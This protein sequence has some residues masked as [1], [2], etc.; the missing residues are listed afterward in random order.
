MR[1]KFYSVG[2][3]MK[4]SDNI[5]TPA[6]LAF[7]V[8]AYLLWGILPL[9]IKLLD[10][11]PTAEIVA[12]RVVWSVPIAGLA[13]VALGRTADIR[14]ALVSPST[15]AMGALMAALV[16]INWGIYIWAIGSCNTLDAALGY[17]IN[18]LFS[19]ALGALFLGERPNSLQ[20]VSIALASGAVL[21]L[22]LAV[23]KVPWAAMGLFISWGLYTLCKKSCL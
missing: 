18:P 15:L 9:Y 21:I 11:I 16:S 19:I 17:Y 22:I 20:M 8:S 7:A 5:D 12:H 14:A 10:H 2:Q 6:G 13:L 4:N 3:G 1:D 23:G